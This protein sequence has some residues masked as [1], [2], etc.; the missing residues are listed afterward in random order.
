MLRIFNPR[1]RDFDVQDLMLEVSLGAPI[2]QVAVGNF[3]SQTVG[4]CCLAV[5]LPRRLLVY[6]VS[7]VSE[8]TELKQ[9]RIRPW[10]T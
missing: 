9:V 2:L 4:K 6:A 7:T 5:L 3:S 8:A 10:S 1:Q